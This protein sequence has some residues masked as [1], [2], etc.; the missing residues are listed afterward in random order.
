MVKQR[1]TKQEFVNNTTRI[2]GCEQQPKDLLETIYDDIASNEISPPDSPSGGAC[3]GARVRDTRTPIPASPSR[4]S[5]L[6]DRRHALH[7][8]AK[9]P[10][11]FLSVHDDSLTRAAAP[12]KP[13][14]QSDKRF[15]ISHRSLAKRVRS[16]LR[17]ES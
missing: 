15:G 1:M 4:I 5:P 11:G 9:H 8:V 12:K 14:K 13:E 10:R 3:I 16:F 2:K 7:R 6:P 17:L